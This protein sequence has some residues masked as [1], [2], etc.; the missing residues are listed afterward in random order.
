MQRLTQHPSFMHEKTLTAL[1]V[2]NKRTERYLAQMQQEIK[3]YRVVLE[4]LSRQPLPA[5]VPLVRTESWDGTHIVENREVV[6]TLEDEDLDLQIMKETLGVARSL[7]DTI[8]TRGSVI[9]QTSSGGTTHRGSTYGEA[10]GNLCSDSGETI[11]EDG[12]WSGRLSTETGGVLLPGYMTDATPEDCQTAPMVRAMNDQANDEL[13][14]SLT[15]RLLSPLELMTELLEE[16]V[17][18]AK[19]DLRACRYGEAKSYLIKATEQ[20]EAR[21]AAYNWQ[22]DEKLEI[23]TSLAAAYIGLEEFDLAERTL[24]SLLPLAADKPLNLGEIHYSIANLHRTRYCQI[25]D[26]AVLD[27][28]EQSAR[29]SYLFALNSPIIPKPFL[30]H[31]AEIMIE[32]S[33]WK[34]DHVAARTFRARHPIVPSV[35]TSTINNDS[36]FEQQANQ[37]GSAPNGR[38]HSSEAPSSTSIPSRHAAQSQSSI[39]E[40]PCRESLSSPPTSIG[41]IPLQPVASVSF[42]AK[43]RGG[44]VEMTNFLLEMGSD[45]EQTDDQSGLTP[46][47]IAAK[48]KHTEMCRALLTNNHAR[49]DIHAKDRARRNVL[50]IALFGSGG[51]DMIPLRLEHNADPNVADEEGKT[52]LHYCVEFNKRRAAQDLISK[53]AKK[54]TPNLAGET[55][56]CLAIRKRKTELVELFLREGAVVDIK[57][58]PRTSKDIE[59][60]VE[61][62]LA[63]RLNSGTESIVTRQDSASTVLSGQTDQT[64]ASRL[65]RRSRLGSRFFRKSSFCWTSRDSNT[66]F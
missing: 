39:Q 45:V 25:K 52:P 13:H 22:F 47:L 19:R 54:E 1:H 53:N 57:N 14:R 9:G 36:T 30:T 6:D 26:V 64:A 41:K 18:Q 63:R 55:A 7:V 44:D 38:D 61:Q 27:R 60:I 28:L 66:N 46:L 31:S 29:S 4:S 2:G 51:E 56:L 12:P 50:H 48:S 8:S 3:R 17:L 42:L 32:M 59:F 35:P 37:S 58:M 33:E 49:A 23:K 15:A 24:R 10:H 11:T 43:V 20:G 21:E 62:H 40:S 65:S 34:G 5:E 16:Y